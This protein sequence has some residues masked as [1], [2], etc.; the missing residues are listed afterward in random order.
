MDAFRLFDSQA[1]SYITPLDLLTGLLQHFRDCQGVDARGVDLFFKQYSLDDGIQINQLRFCD[2]TKSLLPVDRDLGEMLLERKPRDMGRELSL[3]ELFD[4]LTWRIYTKLWETI[5]YQLK[6]M[7]QLKK[8]YLSANNFDIEKAFFQIDAS[9]KGAVDFFD[10]SFFLQKV[11][12]LSAKGI[13][14][15]R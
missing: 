11:Q 5:L 1:A 12:K 9:R 10:V 4:P 7:D 6:R 3:K 14:D 2:F 15:R 13:Q 8:E